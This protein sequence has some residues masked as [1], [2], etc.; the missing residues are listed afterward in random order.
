MTLTKA[1]EM[2]IVAT[3]KLWE[4]MDVDTVCD[5]ARENSTDPLVPQ[6]S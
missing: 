1:D 5:I 3:H 6:L 4:Y 2:L